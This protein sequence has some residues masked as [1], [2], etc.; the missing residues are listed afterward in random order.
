MAFWFSL[1]CSFIAKSG[2]SVNITA[3]VLCSIS[4]CEFVTVIVMMSNGVS[5]C[6]TDVSY[7]PDNCGKSDKCTTSIRPIR[8]CNGKHSLA[9]QHRRPV[10]ISFSNAYAGKT[11]LSLREDEKNKIQ[12]PTMGY[13][14]WVY[15]HTRGVLAAAASINYCD[16]EHVPQFVGNIAIQNTLPKLNDNSYSKL[17]RSWEREST[18]VERASRMFI[19][20]LY[21]K[22]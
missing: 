8:H 21:N 9:T 11:K 19:G 13:Y 1:F 2:S 7:N 18:A 10:F 17:E 6:N 20:K 14:V 4:I 12:L 5:K 3:Y 15:G 16:A 22:F